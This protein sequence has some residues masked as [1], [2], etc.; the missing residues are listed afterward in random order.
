M[1]REAQSP[2]TCGTGG[3][4]PLEQAPNKWTSL[5]FC[6]LRIVFLGLRSCPS[7]QLPPLTFL[8]PA[9]VPQRG[10]C[11]S[12]PGAAQPGGSRCH[13]TAGKRRARGASRVT[14]LANPASKARAPPLVTEV[15]VVKG[16]ERGKARSSWRRLAQGDAGEV[17]PEE[18]R[19]W[20]KAEKSSMRAPEQQEQ[21][22]L[23]SVMIEEDRE[24][25]KRKLSTANCE[26]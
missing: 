11:A 21:W 7:L 5:P 25:T 6:P 10:L 9:A 22:S 18:T 26:K 13:G 24:K 8:T 14:L 4:S 12:P 15:R 16:L 20:G 19:L 1:L 23:Y 3:A 17:A 2:S